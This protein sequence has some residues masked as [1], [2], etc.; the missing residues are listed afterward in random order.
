MP[1]LYLTVA[2]LVEIAATTCLKYADGLTKLWPSI[3]TI[4]GYVV[5]FVL[6]AQ[7]LRSIDVSVAYAIWSGAGTAVIAAIGIIW[8]G[9]PAT[10]LKLG[11]VALIVAGVVALN[12][13]G[14]H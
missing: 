2:I 9:E 6:L 1:A 10:A 3:G 12:L 4:V 13:G 7:A 8:L 5:S 11:G 14:A